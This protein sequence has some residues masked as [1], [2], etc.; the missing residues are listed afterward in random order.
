MVIDLR[1]LRF[2][3]EK[4]GGLIEKGH[5]DLIYVWYRPRRID[6]ARFLRFYEELFAMSASG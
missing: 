4:M 3:T 2:G 1:M 5:V 6:L